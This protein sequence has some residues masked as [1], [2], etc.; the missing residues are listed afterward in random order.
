[1][2]ETENTDRATGDNAPTLPLSEGACD[3]E[4]VR[5]LNPRAEDSLTDVDRYFMTTG[6]LRWTHGRAQSLSRRL[7]H[8]A[9][10]R[11]REGNEVK[12]LERSLGL[13]RRKTVSVPC[14]MLAKIVEDVERTPPWR[15]VNKYHARACSL[16]QE[17]CAIIK[18][19]ADDFDKA[20]PCIE[21]TH[22]GG[23]SH[24]KWQSS[25]DVR[26]VTSNERAIAAAL[27]TDSSEPIDIDGD[28]DLQ[29]LLEEDEADFQSAVQNILAS[30]ASTSHKEDEDAAVEEETLS[31]RREETAKLRST[32][33]PSKRR[34]STRQRFAYA[35][36]KKVWEK[37]LDESRRAAADVARE[38]KE[39]KEQLSTDRERAKFK[40]LK[41]RA[42]VEDA[43]EAASEL[44]RVLSDT[45]EREES[46][47]RGA[48]EA[49][50]A[51]AGLSD[52]H[53]ATCDLYEER[54]KRGFDD[55]EAARQATV[56]L[57]AQLED[58]RHLAKLLTEEA[59]QAR[60][61]LSEQTQ[62]L[63]EQ[64]LAAQTVGDALS[65]E[66]AKSSSAETELLELRRVLVDEKAKAS[67]TTGRLKRLLLST[68]DRFAQQQQQRQRDVDERDRER[69]LAI[70][71]QAAE[72][73]AAGERAEA[74]R[75]EVVVVKEK[76]RGAEA[77]LAAACDG[78]RTTTQRM[79]E[80][81]A[82]AVALLCRNLAAQA[83]R[84]HAERRLRALEAQLAQSRLHEDQAE[85]IAARFCS[86]LD[87]TNRL[88][89]S[90]ST[91]A[92]KLAKHRLLLAAREADAMHL[93]D[94]ALRNPAATTTS[95]TSTETVPL[96][97]VSPNPD[98]T[99][100][101]STTESN[102]CAVHRVASSLE[103]TSGGC[104][105]TA[106]DQAAD[107]GCQPA[108]CTDPVDGSCSAPVGPMEAT[109]EANVGQRAS[110]ALFV[111]GQ[112]DDALV[113]TDREAA[114]LWQWSQGKTGVLPTTQPSALRMV[115]AALGSTDAG[116]SAQPGL[117]LR[118]SPA[119]TTD[120]RPHNLSQMETG[121]NPRCAPCKVDDASRLTTTS[122]SHP[123]RVQDPAQDQR[124]H[125]KTEAHPCAPSC[126]A[127]K[128]DDASRLTTTSS[129][130]Q[131]HV[132]DPSQDQ[133]LHV[134][135]E[136][137][138]GTPSCSA[139]KVDDASRLT[140]S[141]SSHPAH[142]VQ[143]PARNQRDARI[144][145]RQLEEPLGR[146]GTCGAEATNE[147]SAQHGTERER[148]AS[149]SGS[150]GEAPERDAPA[151][152]ESGGNAS[153]SVLL[154]E[155][156]ETCGACEPIGT[157]PP[158]QGVSVDGS[159]ISSVLNAD[160]DVFACRRTSSVRF[161]LSPDGRAGE[162]PV[163]D[164]K[165]SCPAAF[166]FASDPPQPMAAK[167]GPCSARHRPPLLPP[168]A[169][170]SPANR[171]TAAHTPE[172]ALR[173]RPPKGILRHSSLPRTAATPAHPDSP[174]ARSMHSEDTRD[175]FTTPPQVRTSAAGVS[176][177]IGTDASGEDPG[178]RAGA[179]RHAVDVGAN[180]ASER[181]TGRGIRTDAYSAR[182][183]A[184]KAART[185]HN[186]VDD[187]ANSA[188]ERSTG[189]GIR[190]DAY[191][192]RKDADKAA[193]THTNVVHEDANSVTCRGTKPDAKAADEEEAPGAAPEPGGLVLG[194][195]AR[196]SRQAAAR[197]PPAPKKRQQ[198]PAAGGG[199]AALRR[200]LQ[201]HAPAFRGHLL[202]RATRRR[203]HPAP[204][205]GQCGA[206]HAAQPS[207]ACDQQ[208]TA[209]DEGGDLAAKGGR[210]AQQPGGHHLSD[211][212]ERAADSRGQ[213]GCT[214]ASRGWVGE[215]ARPASAGHQRVLGVMDEGQPDGRH[216][217][218]D[219]DE[220][221]AEQCGQ[222]G[223][224]A[225][226]SWVGDKARPASAGKR[227]VHGLMDEGQPDGYRHSFNSDERAADR[228][229]QNGGMAANSWVGDKVRPAS[230]GQ[231]RVQ[232]DGCSDGEP[233][234][235]F[236]AS[237]RLMRCSGLRQGLE[238]SPYDYFGKMTRARAAGLAWDSLMGPAGCDA[239]HLRLPASLAARKK[240]APA[241]SP[242]GSP[243]GTLQP[244]PPP[245]SDPRAD[246]EPNTR[247][248]YL[249]GTS[250]P[251]TPVPSRSRAGKYY[252]KP[253]PQDPRDSH[254]A[255]DP[256]GDGPIP[257][258]ISSVA[259]RFATGTQDFLVS[260]S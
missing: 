201:L 223:G 116:R 110:G 72:A 151:R 200:A 114:S 154:L 81:R 241:A 109:G 244:P 82:R 23:G 63:A 235:P 98:T 252:S 68:E 95:P 246:P 107:G 135:T 198:G 90:L 216:H 17:A 79:L 26:K 224:M 183:D 143:D 64:K 105:H 134:K 145:N 9:A 12:L 206:A 113:A 103:V 229:G 53:A 83:R 167:E 187:D 234:E 141:S 221:A 93:H 258:G 75:R 165:A 56:R 139:R 80:A 130:H 179:G 142:D 1:M 174:L 28:E 186:V 249:I 66:R 222:N 84:A 18:Q 123:A 163:V 62:T 175:A 77:R 247:L 2:M 161:V 104:D 37:Q 73:R 97:P 243:P 91:A 147:Q 227:R 128:V 189:R 14:G 69:Q 25:F 248:R 22:L 102:A 199:A 112:D 194:G 253:P 225:A 39:A 50:E 65:Q 164:T 138:P 211:S 38:L 159:A 30:R 170:D 120:A 217:P 160:S 122:T 231:R 190:T 202:S 149:C 117:V 245:P 124:P 214:A 255:L 152:G 88:K 61:R 60:Q 215:K 204:C 250:F 158:Q 185:Q 173:Q 87:E 100:R 157:Q 86:T 178:A 35:V 188:S 111:C 58:S 40:E 13:K 131:A 51:L 43:E 94:T 4:E 182:K 126:S 240:V 239:V 45:R 213:S 168:Q 19:T 203:I 146:E 260:C 155:D 177:E 133:R 32:S 7:V 150:E 193:R 76:L 99:P 162:C 115:D 136:A 232:P 34:S 10:S 207:R 140:T 148:T 36:Q 55:T 184:D 27:A 101:S 176:D 127:C 74:K 220:R 226:S 16:Q 233:A 137:H 119:D 8:R 129:S 121:A 132:Q 125:M 219:S 44:R 108:A 181:S 228:C 33:N 42:R 180:S 47:L 242:R 46:A 11:I 238:R 257:C 29:S 209:P 205:R 92:A 59:D 212:D 106:S 5:L 144:R 259:G 49:E 166:A 191:S 89:A 196:V 48:R 57:A 52:K 71:E 67:N 15:I 254:A 208:R 192:A 41:L 156:G 54:L 78:Q 195:G 197:N 171:V 236:A 118:E 169:F 31:F 251:R 70:D 85:W 96:S 172:P 230:A 24:T 20:R 218:L 3:T 21:G 237:Q 153:G 210:P 256:L 6:K